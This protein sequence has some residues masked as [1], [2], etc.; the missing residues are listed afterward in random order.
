MATPTQ[1][2]AEVRHAFG[3]R[4]TVLGYA[5]GRPVYSGADSEALSAAMAAV[6]RCHCCCDTGRVYTHGEEKEPDISRR[7]SGDPC[8]SCKGD[9]T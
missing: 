1:P 9:L 8:P 3:V 7:G 2:A 5:D 4:L 6:Y